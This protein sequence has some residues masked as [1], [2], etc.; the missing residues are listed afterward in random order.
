[1]SERDHRLCR[2]WRLALMYLFFGA[3]ARSMLMLAHQATDLLSCCNLLPCFGCAQQ[4]AKG[5]SL[6]PVTIRTA[7]QVSLFKIG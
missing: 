2:C 4:A 5:F 1:M 6:L 7:A 3:R